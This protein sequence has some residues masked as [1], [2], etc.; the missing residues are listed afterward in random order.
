MSFEDRLK[1]SHLES[2]WA[3]GQAALQAEYVELRARRRAESVVV[4]WEIGEGGVSA[5]TVLQDLHNEV[6]VPRE[7]TIPRAFLWGPGPGHVDVYKL[8]NFLLRDVTPEPH[9]ENL[10]SDRCFDELNGFVYGFG[11]RMRLACRWRS[12]SSSRCS[13]ALATGASRSMGSRSRRRPFSCVSKPSAR[14]LNP[15]RRSRVRRIRGIRGIRRISRISRISRII[16]RM[17]VYR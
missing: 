2:S 6:G 13:W 8:I 7:I 12:S 16:A 11:D 9:E 17:V 15:M 3:R 10:R 4:R 5:P 1:L 14:R